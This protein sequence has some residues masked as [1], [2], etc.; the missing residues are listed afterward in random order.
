MSVIFLFLGGVAAG[1][2]LALSVLNHSHLYSIF[3]SFQAIGP[4]DY[5]ANFT[6]QSNVNSISESVHTSIE[7]STSSS[8]TIKS[9]A[10]LSLEAS[11]NPAVISNFP[12]KKPKIPRPRWTPGDIIAVSAR[13]DLV[14]AVPEV[15][16]N[17]IS[18]RLSFCR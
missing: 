11:I 2:I 7:Q 8:S 15:S 12:K 1:V 16:V 14:S 3:N 18:G 17:Q 13:N 4:V 10:K 9:I 6:K 5:V